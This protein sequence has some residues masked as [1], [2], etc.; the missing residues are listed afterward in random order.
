MKVTILTLFAIS[1]SLL[2]AETKEVRLYQLEKRGKDGSELYYL[3][4]HLV[5]HPSHKKPYTG[6][7]VGYFH[8]KKQQKHFRDG[9]LVFSDIWYK[10]NGQKCAE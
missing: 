3:P 2:G 10:K 6:K 5:K 7:A 9:K 8:D 4:N 1:L